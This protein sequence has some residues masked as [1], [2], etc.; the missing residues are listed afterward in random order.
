MKLSQLETPTLLFLA[1]PGEGIF[2]MSLVAIV[3]F[4]EHPSQVLFMK[5]DS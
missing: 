4:V 3:R 1:V 5:A 2:I